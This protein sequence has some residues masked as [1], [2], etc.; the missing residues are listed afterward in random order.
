M[1][2]E[3]RKLVTIIILD[4][5]EKDM[6]QDLKSLGVKGFTVSIANGEGLSHVRDNPWEG[7]NVR[8]ETIVREDTAE[9][10]FQLLAERYFDR[11]SVI[12]YVSDV[13]VFRKEKFQ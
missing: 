7:T 8:I 13:Q 1:N 12:A 9:K 11:Y 6:I 10:I 4:V 5:L 2:L 3:K